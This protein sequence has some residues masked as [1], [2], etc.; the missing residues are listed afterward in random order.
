MKT[1][2]QKHKE[3]L[4]KEGYSPDQIDFMLAETK[5]IWR[6]ENENNI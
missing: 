1:R 3:K 2:L 6:K 5:K 4:I